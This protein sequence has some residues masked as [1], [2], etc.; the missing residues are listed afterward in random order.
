MQNEEWLKD[1]IA[2]LKGLKAR[3]EQQEL[4]VLLAEKPARDAS[5]EKKLKLL[6]RAEKAAERAA[7]ARNAA[8][9]LIQADRKAERDA[10]RKARNHRLILQGTLIDLAGLENRS[11]AEIL[12]ALLS[13]ASTDDAQR[14]ASWRAKGEALL[15][16]KGEPQP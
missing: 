10:E 9:R 6:V 8:T 16:E 11:R 2:Y 7:K 3:S 14:W 5:D 13:A 15:A 4:L 1:R 12:G